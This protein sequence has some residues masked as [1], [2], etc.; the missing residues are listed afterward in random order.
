M[1]F[2][3]GESLFAE[4]PLEYLAEIV[5]STDGQLYRLPCKLT[6]LEPTKKLFNFG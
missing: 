4:V 6:C 2:S 1:L 5:G 3:F